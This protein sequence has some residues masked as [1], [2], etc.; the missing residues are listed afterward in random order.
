M[1]FS[2]RLADWIARYV[3]ADA[4]VSRELLFPGPR[5]GMWSHATLTSHWKRAS[6]QAGVPVVPLREAT[7]HSTATHLRREGWPLDLIQRFLG[8]RDVRNTER[9]SRHHDEA[10]V[11]L[12]RGRRITQ[13]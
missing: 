3:P 10:L 1:P 7:R 8:H 12:V 4:R 5:G 9:Y 6:R 11:A 2:D 13:K